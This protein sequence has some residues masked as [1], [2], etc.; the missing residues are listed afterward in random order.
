MIVRR[1]EIA[2]V[3]VLKDDEEGEMKRKIGMKMF[4]SSRLAKMLF[5]SRPS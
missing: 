2:N 3:S 4:V 1:C 5:N